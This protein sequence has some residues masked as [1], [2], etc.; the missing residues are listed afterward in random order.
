[1][2]VPGGIEARP[3]RVGH[4]ALDLVIAGSAILI[5][6]ISLFIAIQQS[7]TMQ[8]QVAAASWPLLQFSSE[9]TDEHD[10]P[11]INMSITNAGV[12][13]ALIK[14]FRIIYRG[15]TYDGYYPFLDA[16]CGYSVAA[17]DSTKV[18]RG[19][20]QTSF[21]EGSVIKAGENRPFLMMALTPENSSAWKKLD[22]ARFELR[23]DAC[24]CSVLGDCWQSDLRVLDPKPV[25]ACPPID[26][27]KLGL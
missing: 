24:Y 15:R 19:T 22:A 21:I 20:P 13:P 17:D 4:V 12:G 2:V 18:L 1:M 27:N 23:F 10:R 9:N 8:K 26:P 14:R 25:K 16:C 11:V 5:S 7:R 3:R 6:C